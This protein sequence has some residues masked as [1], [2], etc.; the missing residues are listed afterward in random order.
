[1]HGTS[2]YSD[3]ALGLAALFGAIG[4]AHLIGPC[5]LRAAYQRWDYPRRFRLI[6]G[7]AEIVAAAWLADPSLR[8]WGIGLAVFISFGAV[9]TLLNHGRYLQAVPGMV[10]ML[11]LVPAAAAVPHRARS[12]DFAP[13]FESASASSAVYV[14]VQ[15]AISE[16]AGG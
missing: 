13:S 9:V 15:R 4:V 7:V 1:M 3:V 11:A 16:S 10:M 12:V 8:V 6:V 2:F 5:W 14:A